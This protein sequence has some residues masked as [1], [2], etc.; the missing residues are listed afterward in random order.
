MSELVERLTAKSKQI[1]AKR[2]VIMAKLLELESSFAEALD[3]LTVY[4]QSTSVRIEDISPDDWIYGY[5]S[6]Y[7][8]K[9]NV[10]YR[11]TEDDFHDSMRGVPE[12]YQTITTKPLSQ[13]SAE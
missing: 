11:S 8:S 10:G 4:G 13:C 9:L 7:Q 6:F 2:T 12:E 1:K 5:L 3:G